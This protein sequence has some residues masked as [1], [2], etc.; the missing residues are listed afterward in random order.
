[1]PYAFNESYALE[2]L[3]Q[4]RGRRGYRGVSIATNYLC[5]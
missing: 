1:M 2:A 5:L 4:A 3:A